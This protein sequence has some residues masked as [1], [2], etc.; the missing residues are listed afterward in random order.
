MQLAHKAT[1]TPAYEELDDILAV[2]LNELY[3]TGRK[4][5]IMAN[6]DN[7]QWYTVRYD[8]NKPYSKY[9]KQ[10]TNGC[11]KQHL[12]GSAHYG[13][14]TNVLT[15]FITFD[16]DFD[17][18]WETC[19]KAHKQLTTYL[20]SIGV[21]LNGQHT[22][23]S[24][25]KGVHLTLY[26]DDV[27]EFK[28]LESF[29]KQA[30]HGAGLECYLDDKAKGA[31]KIELKRG[32]KLPL[33]YHHKTR[34]KCVKLDTANLNKVLPDTDILKIDPFNAQQFKDGVVNAI[35]PANKA[36]AEATQA[37]TSNGKANTTVVDLVAGTKPLESY[38]KYNAL[39]FDDLLEHGVINTGERH[40]TLIKLA[41]YLNGKGYSIADTVE[42]LTAWLERVEGYYLTPLDE[43]VSDMEGVVEWVYS[44]NV[45]LKPQTFKVDVSPEEIQ[46]ILTATMAT[47]KQFTTKRKQ[48][49]FAITVHA[50][51]YGGE[52]FY[53]TYEQMASASPI[54]SRDKLVQAITEFEK[55]GLIA[56]HRR[57]GRIQGS[58]K[59]LPNVY[60]VLFLA[61]E[62][63][64]DNSIGSATTNGA[65]TL[66]QLTPETFTGLVAKQ[67]SAKELRKMLPYDQAKTF[68]A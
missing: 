2:R 34:N 42:K 46:A 15:K 48:L 1:T 5:F 45:M 4:W 16:F 66:T 50:K 24:G 7:G 22:Y 56:I 10:L 25:S 18:S 29:F 64:A 51:R 68:I 8:E 30:I 53:M 26:F 61:K 12:E 41:M 37:R 44:R 62:N 11:I 43:A 28:L 49:L 36:R 59:S 67:F 33:G 63:T 9:N 6:Y 17:S 58:I 55:A 57:N 14:Y 65:T 19:V 52:K 38:N 39:Y 23:Y 40:E 60:E 3:V 32:T 35:I 20:N 54:K 13:T 31:N 47:G 21:P 27:I